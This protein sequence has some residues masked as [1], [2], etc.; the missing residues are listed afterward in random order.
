M[1]KSQC[2][3]F[4]MQ[5]ARNIV[6]LVRGQPQLIHT[7]RT[8]ISRESSVSFFFFFNREIHLGIK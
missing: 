1:Y 2:T 6:Y 8:H 4:K 7:S 3:M 5:A